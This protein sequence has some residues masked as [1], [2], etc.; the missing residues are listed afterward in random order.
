[1]R[2]YK[3]TTTEIILITY[4]LTQ[5]NQYIHNHSY[6][7]KEDK[8]FLQL[9]KLILIIGLLI[10]KKII[11]FKLNLQLGEIHNWNKVF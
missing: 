4:N 1:M 10:P 5:T 11:N 2:Q 7:V 8:V 9:V 6:L 3:Q